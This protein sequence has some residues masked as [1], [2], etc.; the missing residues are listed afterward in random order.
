MTHIEP[1]D[2]DSTRRDFI[3]IAT[4][5]MGVFGAGAVA[6]PFIDQMN[7]SADALIWVALLLARKMAIAEVIGMDGSVP[8][9]ALTMINRV[10]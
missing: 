5:A 9:I 8:A 10:E 1:Y 7:L 6:W 3:Y 4:G 2:K